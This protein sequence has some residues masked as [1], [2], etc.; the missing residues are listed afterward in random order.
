[1]T[2]ILSFVFVLGVLI[3]VHEL[4]HFLMARRIGVRVLTFSLGFGP[5]LLSFR[6]GDT[7]YCVSAIPLGGYVKM[8]GEN[9]EDTRTGASDEFLS[10]GKWQRFQ[11]LVMGPVMNLAFALVVMALVLYQG[12]QVPAYLERPAVIGV[13]MP[14]SPAAK[15]GLQPHDEI[16]SVDGRLVPTWEHFAMALM[17]KAGRDVNLLI[18]REGRPFTVSVVPDAVDKFEIGDIGILPLVFPQIAAVNPDTP[19]QE[20]GLQP[21][22]I[23]LAVGAER[24]VSQPRVIELI[25][26]SQ[27]RLELEVRR[28]GETRTIT[29]QPRKLD[30]DKLKIG[31]VI[32]RADFR[33]IKPGPIEAVRL[34]VEQNWKWTRLIFE[35]LA[36]L[37]TG[38]ASVKQ[39]MGPVAIAQVSDAAAQQGWVELFGLM[40]MISLNL[41]LLNLMPIPVLDGG[42]IAILAI[43]GLS[44]RDFSMKV[45]E[46]M[47][48]VGFVLL[49]T[50][51]VTVIYNDLTRVQWIER[52]MIWR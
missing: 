33:T 31:A 52:F 29:V 2:T 8:A 10:K 11:V 15:A 40:A 26:A 20:A 1:M 7:E 21:G 23:I 42:H 45:K 44:R 3:F 35:T 17:P 6:R 32:S 5:K 39:L 27:G 18:E 30:D 28:A 48:L 49:V 16:V 19:A 36:G 34:S 43:E 51:M 22:D 37:L 13:V 47:L 41:G 50:L 25:Q 14:D 46:K 4:G 38:A 12:A 24:E 9:P